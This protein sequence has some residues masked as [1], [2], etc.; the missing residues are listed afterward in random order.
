MK[1]VLY[2]LVALAISYAL[3]CFLMWSFISLGS[4]PPIERA[5]FLWF[6]IIWY[7]GLLGIT[8]IT[9]EDRT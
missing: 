8:E 2:I 6:S 4:L 3:L 7:F 9:N 5:L 1:H